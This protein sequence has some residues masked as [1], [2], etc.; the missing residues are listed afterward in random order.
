M[1]GMHKFEVVEDSQFQPR[2]TMTIG[3]FSC[4]SFKLLPPFLI[5][6]CHLSSLEAERSYGPYTCKIC[7]FWKY[8]SPILKHARLILVPEKIFEDRHLT[9]VQHIS[10]P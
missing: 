3:W 1:A 10:Q 5:P 4:Q 6:G 7:P 2:A 8:L 9:L